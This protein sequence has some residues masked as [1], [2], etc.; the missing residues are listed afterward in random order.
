MRFALLGQHIDFN[1]PP[2]NCAEVPFDPDPS[3]SA[4]PNPFQIAPQDADLFP[5]RVRE[6]QPL[7][8]FF[9]RQFVFS[10]FLVVKLVLPL[11]F[12][13]ASH[14]AVFGLHGGW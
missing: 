8:L 9:A 3:L 13:G 2:A 7:L 1:F 4:R 12:E 11:A 14:Q 5:L 10:G 6:L